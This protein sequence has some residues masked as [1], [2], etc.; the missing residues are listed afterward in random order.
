MD[1]QPNEP[2][3]SF[4][5]AYLR[6]RPRSGVMST[7]GPRSGGANDVDHVSAV[8]S[9]SAKVFNAQEQLSSFMLPD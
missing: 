5:C 2:S 8:R 3:W 1:L 4:H 7:R 6:N 9:V